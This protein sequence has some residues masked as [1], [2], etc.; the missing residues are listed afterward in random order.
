MCTVLLV[1][2][3]AV[4]AG[5]ESLPTRTVS[6]ETP[7]MAWF[8]G[9]RCTDT[10]LCTIVAMALLVFGGI[11][12]FKV[13]KIGRSSPRYIYQMSAGESPR[14]A[15]LISVV[16]TIALSLIILMFAFQEMW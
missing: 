2:V 8:G 4:I 14:D 1:F 3:S 5:Q 9:L 6:L 13:Q 16:V 7:K 10:E 11:A 15:V 12:L